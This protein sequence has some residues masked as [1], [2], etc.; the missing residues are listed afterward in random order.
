MQYVM[1]IFGGEII[2]T[3]FSVMLCRPCS[4]LC[5]GTKKLLCLSVYVYQFSMSPNE[6]SL[7]KFVQYGVYT[8]LSI[9]CIFTVHPIALSKQNAI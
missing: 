2:I 8:V 9:V 7:Q 4:V 1:W 5:V 3:R 6:F